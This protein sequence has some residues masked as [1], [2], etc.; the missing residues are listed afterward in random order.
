M[1]FSLQVAIGL[2][3]ILVLIL[4]IAIK[5]RNSIPG[6]KKKVNK[7]PEEL[8]PII[9]DFKW[10]YS[11]CIEGKQIDDSTSSSFDNLSD[12]YTRIFCKLSE[13]EQI[14]FFRIL[15]TYQSE[16]NEY[17]NQHKDDADSTG[18][19]RPDEWYQ[20]LSDLFEDVYRD[21]LKIAYKDIIAEHSLEFK[22]LDFTKYQSAINEIEIWVK[23]SDFDYKKQL[24]EF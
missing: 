7:L 12:F 10:Y 9:D 5:L 1:R 6:N 21:T 19:Y 16:I 8:Q 17:V 23:Q 20:G 24:G 4:L 2:W 11:N 18:V 22:T 13:D 15:F 3:I 14:R